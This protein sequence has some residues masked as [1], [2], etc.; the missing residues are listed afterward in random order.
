MV[1]L[2]VVALALA[3]SACDSEPDY[4]LCSS[5]EAFNDC[6]A[7]DYDC[8]RTSQCFPCV[9]VS[10]VCRPKCHKDSDCPDVHG[11][12]VE[13]VAMPDYAGTCTIRCDAEKK[14]PK[15]MICKDEGDEY[16]QC[17]FPAK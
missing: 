7:R 15:G 1:R 5:S 9:D 8:L 12:K 4:S 13:C 3:C 11:A 17:V 6:I 10:S 16:E 2:L 14:C